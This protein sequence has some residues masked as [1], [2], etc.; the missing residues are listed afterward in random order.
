MGIFVPVIL[1]FVPFIPVIV[2]VIAFITFGREVKAPCANKNVPA[3]CKWGCIQE[4]VV[5]PAV[6]ASAARHA[7]LASNCQNKR[8]EMQR[9]FS[10]RTIY[11]NYM[12]RPT[13]RCRPLA[14]DAY[15]DGDPWAELIGL[16][17]RRSK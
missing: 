10:L 8:G 1:V 7:A 2:I 3:E 6:L 17:S 12:T 9:K 4:R 13:T 16:L 11:N 15:V 14:P 5:L